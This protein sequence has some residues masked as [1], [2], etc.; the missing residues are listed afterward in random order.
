MRNHHGHEKHQLFGHGHEQHGETT[1][2][3]YLRGKYIKRRETNQKKQYEHDH[4]PGCI[5]Q[6]GTW[7]CTICMTNM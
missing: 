2:N 5:A 6:C 4:E 7:P 1:M 3:I